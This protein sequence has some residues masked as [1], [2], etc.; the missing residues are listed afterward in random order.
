M[1]GN[2]YCFLIILDCLVSEGSSGSLV[3][4]LGSRA[5]SGEICGEVWGSRGGSGGVLE[6]PLKNVIFFFLGSEF[7]DGLMKYECF[8]FW[9]VLGSGQCFLRYATCLLFLEACIVA[10][11]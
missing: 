10:K 9:V 11:Q 6:R 5:R 2:P 1:Y 4:L 7:V 3:V 8:Q